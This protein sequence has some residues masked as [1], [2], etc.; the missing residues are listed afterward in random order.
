MHCARLDWR[1]QLCT[2]AKR[3]VQS[4]CRCDPLRFKNAPAAAE[5]S[6]DIF[7]T[8]R[9]CSSVCVCVC[10][11]VCAGSIRSRSKE[12]P[13]RFQTVDRHM[14]RSATTDAGLAERALNHGA[15]GPWRCPVEPDRRAHNCG[16]RV[17]GHASKAMIEERYE[18]VAQLARRH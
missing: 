6:F 4:W 8:A 2:H 13:R 5:L 18:R 12:R 1:R 10:V 11:C 14:N 3:R 17:H 15:V 7:A 16:L 9:A